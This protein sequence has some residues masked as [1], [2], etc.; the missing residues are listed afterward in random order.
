MTAWGRGASAQSGGGAGNFILGV[1]AGF[2]L[3][4]IAG[5]ATVR[6]GLIDPSFLGDN[7]ARSAQLSAQVDQLKR[8]VTRLRDLNATGQADARDETEKLRAEVAKLQAERDALAAGSGGIA[9]DRQALETAQAELKELKETSIPRMEEELARREREIWELEARL[10]LAERVT[11]DV[12]NDLDKARG[13]DVQA[14]RDT[15]DQRDKMLAKLDAELTAKETEIAALK[16]QAGKPQDDGASAVAD[17]SAELARKDAAI[18]ERD[19]MLKK[20]DEERALLE[21]QVQAALDEADKVPALETRIKELGAELEAARK[22]PE[23]FSPADVEQKARIALLESRLTFAQQE[24]ERLQEKL[25]ALEAER[26]RGRNIQPKAEDQAAP[27][28]PV[29]DEASRPSRDPLKVASA[30][31]SAQGLESMSDAQ[32]D[33][34][35]IALIEG[36]CVGTALKEAMGRAPAVPLRDLIRS[37]DSD[38]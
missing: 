23:R 14:L 2:V 19:A 13:P 11:N 37:L 29:V 32:R 30:I 5:Y 27:E 12:R 3:L 26:D 38:C 1:F 36:A 25:A 15:I 18:A 31:R 8:E 9:A 35:A 33:K 6:F 17:S 34:L 20:L 4:A 28:G 22:A 16:E 10:Q 7:D 21:K 24:V